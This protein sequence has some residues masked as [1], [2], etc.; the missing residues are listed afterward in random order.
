VT[1]YEPTFQENERLRYERSITGNTG[2]A[3]S[4][5]RQTRRAG[6]KGAVNLRF[7]MNGMAN[8]LESLQKM[9]TRSRSRRFK[10]QMSWM[11]ASRPAGRPNR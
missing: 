1:G 7:S 4:D 10:A 9:M 6:K 8:R 11:K 2:F 3:Q 5:H